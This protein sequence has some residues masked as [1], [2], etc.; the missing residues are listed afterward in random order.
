MGRNHDFVVLQEAR[1]Q[2]GAKAYGIVDTKREIPSYYYGQLQHV[3]MIT[4]LRS[5]EENFVDSFRNK[6]HKMQGDFK[7]NRIFRPQGLNIE[8]H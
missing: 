7:G 4:Q 6:G 2:C 5:A 8:P 1:F 3:L